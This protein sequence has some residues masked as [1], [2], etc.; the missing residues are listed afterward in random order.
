MTTKRV[1]ILAAVAIAVTLVLTLT[2]ESVGPPEPSTTVTIVSTAGPE[3]QGVAFTHTN[4]T[5]KEGQLV[6]LVVDNKETSPHELLI[7]GF[8]V[9]TGMVQGGQTEGVSFVP[10]KTGTFGF[11]QFAEYCMAG[12][13]QASCPLV[14][15]DGNI[16]VL[17]P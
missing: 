12:R 11:G 1:V 4:F 16:T 10:D 2:Y 3:Q 8:D 15:L 5:V 6:T 14:G 13:E 17:P 9:N 7:P